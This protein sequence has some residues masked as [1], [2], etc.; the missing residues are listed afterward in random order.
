MKPVKLYFAG[1]QSLHQQDMEMVNLGIKNRLTSFVYPNQFYKWI[2][3]TGKAKGNMIIDSGAFSAWNKN[4]VIDV[5][6]YLTYARNAV[7]YG[8]DYNKTIRVVNLDVIPGKKGQTYSLNK[9]H[10]TENKDIINKAAADGFK[11]MKILLNNG[12]IPIHV[13]HQGEDWK[14]L[15]RMLDY[16]DYIGISPA[17]DVSTNSK[18][19]WISSVFEYL[20]KKNSKVKTHG[21]AVTVISILRDLPWYSADSASWRLSAAMGSIMYPVN[22]FKNP[23]YSQRPLKLDL[24]SRIN[25]KGSGDTSV[26]IIKLLEKDGYSFELLQTFEERAKVNIKY[27]IGLEQWLNEYKNKHDYKPHLKMELL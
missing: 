3:L 19:E 22:G 4:S 12:I 25:A 17:N 1:D 7:E 6:D 15:D 26:G 23:D 2:E 13:Y 14:W 27:Y 16:T 9:I 20:Y 24:S 10:K 8:K 21:F 11:N 18:K 5:K